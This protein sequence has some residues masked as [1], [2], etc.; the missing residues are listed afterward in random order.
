VQSKCILLIGG[1]HWAD[2][3]IQICKMCFCTFFISLLIASANGCPLSEGISAR[4]TSS[5]IPRE[6]CWQ[7]KI[8][9]KNTN[10]PLQ[11]IFRQLLQNLRHVAFVMLEA[12]MD[13][14]TQRLKPGDIV[15]FTV[16]NTIRCE[17]IYL[18][19]L[20]SWWYGKL[21]LAHGTERKK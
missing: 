4:M 15:A 12:L 3:S 7:R 17:T 6:F 20:K 14:C 13:A 5:L 19:V 2:M 10:L 11:T 16:T 1:E 8:N 21:S 9:L 18:R